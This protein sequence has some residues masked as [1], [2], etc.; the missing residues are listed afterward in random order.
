MPESAQP[1]D[2]LTERVIGAAISVHRALG[3]GYLESL[4]EEALSIELFAIGVPFVRQAPMAVRYRDVE[5][6]H[7]RMDLLVD[8][9][10]IVE[11]KAVDSLAPIHIAQLLSYLRATGLRMG[12]LINFNVPVLKHGIRRVSL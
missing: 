11:L 6:G 7:G 9:T 3:P 5:I 10:L 4:Y 2:P 1:V 8:E 12:L